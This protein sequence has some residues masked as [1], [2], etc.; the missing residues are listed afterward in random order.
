M[1][2]LQVKN[3]NC[4][5]RD[6]VLC[7]DVGFFVEVRVCAWFLDNSLVLFHMKDSRTYDKIVSR[8]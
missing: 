7:L 3:I 1:L 4:P 2:L 5:R 6:I 8:V